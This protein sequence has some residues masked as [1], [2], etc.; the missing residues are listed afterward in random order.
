MQFAVG[1]RRRIGNVRP[2]PIE[3]AEKE[4]RDCGKLHPTAIRTLVK[5]MSR[6]EFDGGFWQY[7]HLTDQV[8]ALRLAPIPG[9]GDAPEA[10]I[11]D[12]TAAAR[13]RRFAF[14][15]LEQG[16]SCLITN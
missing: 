13:F 14:D 5:F 12:Q 3:R 4:L 10:S 16:G 8:P 9:R 1:I 11:D 6:E 7:R 15:R 2:L